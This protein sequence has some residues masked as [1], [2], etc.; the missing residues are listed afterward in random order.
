MGQ[1]RH[2]PVWLLPLLGI[3]F[4]F[5]GVCALIY[6]VMWLRMLALVFGVTVYAASTVLASFMGGLALGS[7]AAGRVASR[8]KS[9]LRTFG[10]IEVGVGIS[11]LATPLVLSAIKAIWIV[12]APS[13]PSSLVFMTAARFLAAFA[14]LIVPTTLMGAT[15]PV[16]MR[17]ALATDRGVGSRI[18][19]LYAINTSGAIVGALVA[20]FYLVAE[21]GMARSFQIAAAINVVIGIIAVVAARY[22]TAPTI[23]AIERGAD[24]LVTDH[25]SVENES[26]TPAQGRAV[27]WTFALSGALSLALE[28]VWFRMLVMM[29][30]PTAY[31]FTIM[32]AAVLAGIAIGS[33]VAAPLL[34]RQRPWLAVLTVVQLLISV[35]AVLSLNALDYLQTASQQLTPVLTRLG[36][37]PYLGPIIVGS[38]L[39]MMPTTL[40]L[41]FAFPIGL[42]LWAGRSDESPRRIGLFYSLNVFGAILGSVLGGF[43]LLPLLGSRGSLIATAAVAAVSSVLLA[44]TQWRMRPNFA[45]FM[46]VVGPIAFA[47]A[48][49]N[50]V[51]PN[52]IT[53]AAQHRGERVM[54]REEGVQTTVAVHDAGRG[55]RS[56]RVMYLDGMHQASDARQMT[57][58]HHRIGAFPVLLHPDPKDALVVGLGGGATGGAVAQYPG[59]SVDVVELSSAVVKGASFFSHINFDVLNRPNV[60][61]RVEDGRNY[62]LTTTKK[63]DIITADIILPR[64][65]GAGALYSRE[66]FDLVRNALKDD[67]LAL[68]W[69]GAEGAAY[70]LILRTFISVFP[71]T[72][73]WADGTLMVGSKKPLEFS[74]SAYEQRRRDPQFRKLFDWEFD[75]IMRTYAGGPPELAAWVGPGPIL[76]DDKPLIEYFLSLPKDEQPPDT[77]TLVARPADIVRP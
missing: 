1:G 60:R 65:A 12:V 54:W 47:M 71:N 50:A 55:G 41:G 76:T 58:V 64:H 66:Y 14:V 40:L 16:V 15:L 74:R 30:R 23:G 22:I 35:A 69:N 67:G 57:F 21:I 49:L 53:Y 52:D 56:N 10:L 46:A 8:L 59:V 39:A 73:L 18:G 7:F 43:I 77:R 11:A 6:Q 17:S 13:M 63:Y 62:L 72:T 61:L 3:L 51:D 70:R 27:L 5:S 48:A 26:L 28:I 37:D 2:S 38:L 36:L 44:V 31:A 42:S 4:F 33:A 25:R 68:Q 34:A 9:P 29:L 45:G 32:L 19:L 75:Q 24:V 20:G